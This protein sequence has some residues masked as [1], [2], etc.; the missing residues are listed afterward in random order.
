MGNRNYPMATIF[1]DDILEWG[2]H[3]A[4]WVFCR[5]TFFV[6]IG[7][8]NLLQMANND[9]KWHKMAKN[10]IKWPKHE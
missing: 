1:D 2:S 3:D 9:I 6:M 5:H 8:K 7:G 10:G 4:G